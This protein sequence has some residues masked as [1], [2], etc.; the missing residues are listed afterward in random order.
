MVNIYKTQVSPKDS[1]TITQSNH[2]VNNHW[3]R[4]NYSYSVVSHSKRLSNHIKPLYP[5]YAFSIWNLLRWS[6]R[7]KEDWQRAKQ[8]SDYNSG[9]SLIFWGFLLLNK[10]LYQDFLSKTEQEVPES[11]SEKLRTYENEQVCISMLLCSA[12][13]RESSCVMKYFGSTVK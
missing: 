8:H 6:H 10:I 12:V 1:V 7:L 9:V 13:Q 3:V 2:W 4:L 11:I 5:L